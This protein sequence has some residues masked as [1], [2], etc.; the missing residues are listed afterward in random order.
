MISQLQEGD[1]NWFLLI[2]EFN[3]FDGVVVPQL[4]SYCD[5]LGLAL[6]LITHPQ[7]DLQEYTCINNFNTI[8]PQV[9]LI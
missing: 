2:Y 1:S 9:F 7:M 8:F 4:V 3:I 6:R 5:H